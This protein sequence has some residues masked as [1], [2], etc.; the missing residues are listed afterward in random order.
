MKSAT[1]NFRQLKVASHMGP[2]FF[3]LKSIAGTDRLSCLF[4][5]DL[6]MLCDS[7]EVDPADMVGQNVTISIES[8]DAHRSILNGYVSRFWYEGTSDRASSYRATVVPWFW[9]LTQTTD[10]R[11][12]QEQTVPEIIETV[13]KDFGFA[14]FDVLHL[15]NSYKKREYCVQ[16]RETDFDFLSRLME[17]EGI[18]YFFRHDNGKHTLHLADCTTA[19]ANVEQHAVDFFPPGH[20]GDLGNHLVSWEHKYRFLPGKVSHTDYNFK[21]PKINLMS[22]EPTRVDIPLMKKLERYDFPGNFDATAMG[23]NLARIR[24]QEIEV[25]YEQVFGAGDYVSFCAAG[26]FQVRSH[27]VPSERGREYVLTEVRLFASEGGTYISGT[28]DTT[29]K[30]QNRFAAMPA[31]VIFRPPRHTPK[32][33]VEGPQT[34]I[35]VGPKGEEIYTDE[36]GRVKVQFHWD[37]RGRHDEKSSCWIRVSQSHAGSGFGGIDIPR[38]GEEII[39]DF[40]EGDPDRPIITGRVYNGKNRPPFAL[41]AGMTRSGMKSNTHKGKGANE[42]SMDDT[43]GAEQIRTHAQYNMDTTVG[44]NQSL[45]VNV[46][47]TESIGS[48][49]SLTVGNN[50]TESVKVDKSVKVGSNMNVDVGKK[51]VINAGSSITLKCGASRIHMNSG[52]VI[53]ISGTIITTAAAANAAV[54]APLTQ[55]VGGVMLTTVGGINMTSGGVCKVSALGLASVSGG[56]VDVVASGVTAIKGGTITLN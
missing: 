27:R 55:V 49:D 4:E 18:Y 22:H 53:T 8:Q 25:E 19:Y 11:I 51:L 44:N 15:R 33:I 24:M 14:D 40:L 38:I 5:Y 36:H 2:D 26:K 32:A 12:F 52:G 6:E 48:N 43:A 31:D 9:F 28:E 29:V 35:V 20:E 7:A 34:A 56:K 1:Q 13:F 42:I 16:Y 17:E 30:Y 21:S 54:A 45:I 50:R 37:R 23:R 39:V 41:P 46:D 47:R 10:C 3:L